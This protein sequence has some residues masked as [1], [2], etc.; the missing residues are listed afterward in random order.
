MHVAVLET[1]LSASFDQRRSSLLVAGQTTRDANCSHHSHNHST[2]SPL[3][4]SDYL[5]QIHTS[6][7][8]TNSVSSPYA[9]NGFVTSIS[10]QP[11]PHHIPVSKSATPQAPR[12]RPLETSA[13]FNLTGSSTHVPRQQLT[14]SPGL[15]WKVARLVVCKRP[16]AHNDAQISQ[17]ARLSSR[18][19]LDL[20]PHTAPA[21]GN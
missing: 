21:H 20:Y 16:S 6:S 1:Y 10:L 2:D 15:L 4:I 14:G 12:R 5:P 7:L 11:A 18:L 13:I 8:T 9:A 17:T 3:L 19:E